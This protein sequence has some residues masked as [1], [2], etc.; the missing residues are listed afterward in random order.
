VDGYMSNPMCKQNEI[1]RIPLLTCLD[2]AWN[3]EA[4]DPSRSVGQAILYLA[5]TAPQ[6]GV[7]KDLVEAYPGMLIYGGRGT[8][9]NAVQEQFTR[10]SAMPHSRQAALAYIEHL[11]Q[12]SDRLKQQFPGHYQ[13][14]KQTLDNDIQQLK[15]R[16]TAKYKGEE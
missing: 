15:S 16:L 9:F 12:L 14:E 2:Y 3:P 7:L 10:I 5:D 4:Y 8:G 6:R 11:Q 13:P 1:N